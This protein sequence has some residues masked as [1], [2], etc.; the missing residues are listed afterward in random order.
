[1]KKK[2]SAFNIFEIVWYSIC[3]GVGLWGLT[4][5]VLGLFAKYLNVNSENNPLLKGSNA[6]A[7]AFGGLGFFEWGLIILSIAVVAAI[8]VLLIGAKGVD[9]EYEKTARRLARRQALHETT[10]TEVVEE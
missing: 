8:I 7:E 2:L 9:R 10:T 3:G 6:I 5:T 4:Y 1:M